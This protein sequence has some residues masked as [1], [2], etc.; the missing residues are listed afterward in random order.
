MIRCSRSITEITGISA[1]SAATATAIHRSSY[2]DEGP[3][4]HRRGGQ[5]Q[6]RV[7]K[8]DPRAAVPAPAP[9][10]H[11]AEHRDV[12]AIADLRAAARAL[13]ARPHDRLPRRHACG[14]DRHE[15]PDRQTDAEDED[16]EDP[17]HRRNPTLRPRPDPLGVELLPE[18]L[19]EPHAEPEDLRDPRVVVDRVPVLDVHRA[20]RTARRRRRLRRVLDRELARSCRGGPRCRRWGP[21]RTPLSNT[22]VFFT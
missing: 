9:Q 17:D 2:D 21:C 1:S 19:L 14:D 5:L 18:R 22:I 13:R 10:Q 4:D 20:A 15:A 8:R 16:A 3:D 7:P 12:V 6:E 11:P